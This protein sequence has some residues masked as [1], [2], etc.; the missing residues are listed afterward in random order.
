[1]EINAGLIGFGTIG[2]G[3]LRLLAQ[4]RDMLERR[5]SISIR[6][7]R[8][9]DID[10]TRDR[11]VSLD[12]ITLTAD[13][14]DIIA[15]KSI[16]VV[17]ELI[18]GT[19]IAYEVVKKALAAKKH[20]VTANKALLYA[21][22]EELFALAAKN[23]RELRF[24]ASVAGGIPIIRVVTEGL[25]GDRI[26][27]LYGIVNGTTNF[28]LT[29]MLDE[30]WDFAAAVK[31]A[32]KLGF[33]EADPTLDINGNDATHKLGILASVAFNA[34]VDRR[35][36]YTDGIENIN[37]K[38]MLYA[39]EL[40]YTIKLLAIAKQHTNAMELRVHPT[41]IPKRCN[42]ASVANEYNAIRLESEFLGIS[43]YIGRGAG[44]NPTATAVVSDLTDLALSVVQKRE[45]NAS[46]YTPFNQ[47]RTIRYT[48]F[49]S[50]FYLRINTFERPGILAT[51][52]KVLGDHNISISSV[53][54]KEVHEDQSIPI[55]FLTHRAKE[56]DLRDAIT[57]IDGLDIIREKT[58]VFHVE[59]INS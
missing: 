47:L 21:Y 1:M 49:E 26:T 20:V 50:R 59:D 14:A 19:T 34:S 23:K 3:V 5:S 56:K 52:T 30:R 2:T 33:A 53:V 25:V 29:K 42:L 46:R 32:Q 15:D 7:S 38:D 24:E 18:G 51:I 27:T 16:D 45:F 55:V 48:D 12:G 40:G 9:A 11:G 10:T 22:G 35:N 58:I 6:V 54:Q 8:I 28:I 41:L 37:I 4:Y 17:I 13:Y 57:V 39:D 43:H 31:E 36:I 44:A